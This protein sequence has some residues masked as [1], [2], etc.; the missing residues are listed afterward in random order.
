MMYFAL[1][2]NSAIIVFT[3]NSVEGKKEALDIYLIEKNI[4]NPLLFK[5]MFLVI[6]EHALMVLASMLI[7]KVSKEP[8]WLKH[9]YKVQ[10]Y[11]KALMIKMKKH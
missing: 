5:F 11:K 7:L 4:N 2:I 8:D 6:F 3:K 9:T 1:I 10:E